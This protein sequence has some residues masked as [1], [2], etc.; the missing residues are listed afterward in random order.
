VDRGDPSSKLAASGHPPAHRWRNVLLGGSCYLILSFVLWWHVW[1]THPTS[2]VLCGCS[3]TSQFVWFLD[4]PAYALSHGLSPFFST[5]VF[6]PQGVNL[7]SVTS[8]LAV[9]IPLAPVTWIFGPVATLNV[10]LLLSPVLSGAAM[11]ILL[12]RWVTWDPAAFIGG[13]LY[14]FSPLI[15]T[16]LYYSHLNL[17]ISPIPP[18]VVACLD[19]IVIRQRRRPILTGVLLGLLVTLQFFLSTELVVIMA[20]A[21]TFALVLLIAYAALRRP[22]AIRQHVHCAV[23]GLASAAVVTV[24]L[25]A[26]PAWFALAGPAHV[27]GLVWI[28][29]G[30]YVSHLTNYLLPHQALPLGWQYGFDGLLISGQYLGIGLVVVLVGGLVVWRRDLKLWLFALVGL[31]SMALSVGAL[32]PIFGS[33]PLLENVLPDRFDQVL[34]LSAAIMLGIVVDHSYAT[35]RQWYTAARQGAGHPAAALAAESERGVDPG[36]PRRAHTRRAGWAGALAG[37]A[38]AVVALVPI[39]LYLSQ[40]APIPVQSSLQVPSWFRTDARH[41]GPKQVLLVLPDSLYV[42]SPLAWQVADGMGYSIVDQAGSTGTGA[43][44]PAGLTVLGIA[45]APPFADFVY[46]KAALTITPSKIAAVRSALHQWGVTMVVIPDQR[47]LARLAQLG[48]VSATAALVTAATGQRPDYR[49]GAWVWSDVTHASAP[50]VTTTSKF[51]KCVNSGLEGH[52]AVH[53]AVDCVLST[54]PFLRLVSSVN[55]IDLARNHLLMTTAADTSAVAAVNFVLTTHGTPGPIT[56]PAQ[57]FT[58]GSVTGW[59]ANL[60][61]A[62]VPDGDYTLRSVASDANGAIG[63]SAAAQVRVDNRTNPLR[64]PLTHIV[65]PTAQA[66]VQGLRYIDAIA[67]SPLGVRGVEIR[68]TGEGHSVVEQA[69]QFLYGWSIR[70]NTKTV[71]DGSYTISSVAE[72]NDGLETTSAGVPVTVKN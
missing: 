64:P 65:T 30:Q 12:R 50:V 55:G 35:A 14:G 53:A 2:S 49:D 44:E 45:T 13:L 47:G 1:S 66:Q 23:V 36:A 7:L 9:G 3:D 19:E 70:W 16:S 8:V 57:P 48:S 24:V 56:I 69:T 34:Y 61:S 38:V 63:H 60:Q 33:L 26:Y 5:A 43:V 54:G 27:S 68:I 51:S 42:L 67:T 40:N 25:L 10:A 71:P 17:A 59:L 46:S 52:A 6:Y 4:W 15:V 28:D 41:L 39:A 11:F 37:L 21:A 18:L 22:G 62:K 32:N 72:G 58:D 31:A 20:L 29:P